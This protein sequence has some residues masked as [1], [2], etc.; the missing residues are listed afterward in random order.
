MISPSASTSN[1]VILLLLKHI[2]IHEVCHI[3][4]VDVDVIVILLSGSCCQRLLGGMAQQI[5]KSVNFSPLLSLPEYV[6]EKQ[7]EQREQ[8]D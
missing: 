7:R 4:H 1:I 3:D 5:V 6:A 2:D 8:K